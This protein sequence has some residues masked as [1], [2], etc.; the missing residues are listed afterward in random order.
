MPQNKLSL[1]AWYGDHMV[2]QQQVRTRLYGTTLPGA[3]VHVSLERFPSGR[4]L[5]S[6]EAEYGVIYRESDYAEPDGFFEFKLPMIEGSYDSFRLSIESVGERRVFNDILFGEV[7]L[8]AGGSNMSM[9]ANLSDVG[10]EIR[11]LDPACGIRF[12]TQSEN[13]LQAGAINYSYTPVGKIYGSN[14]YRAGEYEAIG[15][16]SAVAVSF[17]MHLHEEI[18]MPLAVFDLACPSSF[19]HA[20]LP[21][22]IIEEDAII[23]NHV[24]EI[25]HYRDKDNWNQM[26]E[27]ERVDERYLRSKMRG[28]D[29]AARTSPFMLHNQPSALFNHKLAPYTSLSLR[30]ILWYQGEEDIQY[31]DYY[32]RALMALC[33]IFKSM[34]QSTTTGI[35]FV[36]SQITPRLASNTDSSRLAYFNEALTAVR[37]RLPLK[38]GMITNY[39][40]PLKYNYGKPPYDTPNTPFAKLQI[41]KRMAEVALG[42]AYKSDLPES[43]PECVGAENVG[44]KLLLTFSNAG[45]GIHLRNGDSLVKGFTISGAENY[46]VLAEAKELYQLRVIVW[47]D[48][49]KN[50]QSCTYA[51]QNFNSEANLCGSNGMPL[52]PFRLTREAVNGE[53]SRTWAYC[54]SLEDFKFPLSD[55]RSPR[56]GGKDIPGTYPLWKLYSGRCNFQL[57]KNN[58]RRGN[59]SILLKYSKADERPV[60]F[61]PVLDYV[62]DYPPLDLH[63][64]AELHCIIF[65]T[66]HRRK[67]LRLSLKDVNE[68][69]TVSEVQ[70]IHDLLS[71]QRIVFKLRDAPVD[72]MRLSKV[73]FILQDTESEGSLYIDQIEF[74][75]LEISQ[76]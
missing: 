49:V 59:A 22:N 14:W 48:E 62:S 13:G 60:S 3:A 73:E 31:P 16:I 12:Y 43:A 76:I 29:E 53:K 11:R 34:F 9:P 67:T 40:L 20:W 1:P 56:L 41:G 21:R 58:K 46:Q 54:D 69:E 55:P 6:A 33:Q 36:Y 5:A 4:L 51:F 74:R 57:E 7:W 23:K 71:W 38:S 2:L 45:K 47:H 65:N 72:L 32:Q 27:E 61:G 25:R 15:K 66:E 44:N 70:E 68:R 8:A 35:K 18:N 63:I 52:V 26:P 37:R 39:D 42:M 30:G 24:R 19:I 75:G 17:A 28:K 10:K 64:W 50:P